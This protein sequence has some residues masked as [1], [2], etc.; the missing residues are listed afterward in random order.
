MNFHI[1]DGED[2]Y[3]QGEN[4]SQVKLSLILEAI[5]YFDW[6]NLNIKDKEVQK[7]LAKQ[8]L[9]NIS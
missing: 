2:Y 5:N 3:S 6:S 1:S 8:I 7:R 4:A 9:R